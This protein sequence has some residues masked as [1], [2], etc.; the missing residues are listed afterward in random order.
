MYKTADLLER[1]ISKVLHDG[2]GDY[3]KDF[4]MKL[5]VEQGAMYDDEFRYIVVVREDPK[6]TLEKQG[7][8]G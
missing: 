4:G 5:R 3:M 2:M 7:N 6:A 1:A 8:D